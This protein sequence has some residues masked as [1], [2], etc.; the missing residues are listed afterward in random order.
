MIDFEVGLQKSIKLNF[1]NALISEC[2]FQF[3]KCLWEKAKKLHFFKK[4]KNKHT[5]IF[6]H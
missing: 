6:S 5:K 4:D 1:P 3:V 2:F